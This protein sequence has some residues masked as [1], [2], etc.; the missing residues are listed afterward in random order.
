[1]CFLHGG[2][3]PRAGVRRGPVR[4]ARPRAGLG[5][6]LPQCNDRAASNFLRSHGVKARV[7][8]GARL[9]SNLSL[10]GAL[11]RI[12]P[13]RVSDPV[14]RERAA[15]VYL[16]LGDH[17]ASEGRYESAEATFRKLITE[18]PETGE[19]PAA[20]YEAGRCF[21]RMGKP[22]EAR[23]Q[24][25]A[26]GANV[27]QTFAVGTGSVFTHL[28]IPMAIGCV[29]GILIIEGFLVTTLDTGN[30]EVAAACSPQS[31]KIRKMGVVI[32]RCCIIG[33]I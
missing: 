26:V 12:V 9:D 20:L 4:D 14:N 1:M 10:E 27:I 18:L 2:P 30:T 11:L 24:Y 29:L 6:S 28:G 32:R 17:Y 13:E 21:E 5:G 15:H 3:T 16:W 19:V 23:T 7:Y 8:R 22:V 31:S 33:L 25:K